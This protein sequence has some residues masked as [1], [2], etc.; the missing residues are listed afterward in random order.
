MRSRNYLSGLLALAL[1]LPTAAGAVTV[2]GFDGARV[3]F[4]QYS[5][6]DNGGANTELTNAANFP[7]YGDSITFAASTTLATASYLSSVD[8]FFTGLLAFNVAALSAAEVAAL[9][10]FIDAGGVVIAHGD[11]SGFTAT[12]DA[13]LNVYGLDIVDPNNQVP[14]TVNISTPSH[15]VMNGPFGVVG[16]HGITD[17]ARL[18]PPAG[19]GQVIGTYSDGFGAIGVV[20][21]GGS[22]AGGLLFLPD[23]ESYGLAEPNFRNLVDAKRAFNNGVAWAVRIANAQAVPE[24]GAAALMGLALVGLFARRRRQ[25]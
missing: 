21:P 12:V 9:A 22:R 3:L 18:G 5:V 25:P 20:N 7:L 11:N 23:S 1:V 19:V 14:R 2:G 4:G 10:G 17:S 15:P 24:P 13:L 6:Y 8:I 16:A